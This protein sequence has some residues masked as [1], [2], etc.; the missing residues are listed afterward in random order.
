MAMSRPEL[1]Q[2]RVT[3]KE[4]SDRHRRSH[5]RENRDEPAEDEPTI[6]IDHLSFSCAD[7]Q[8]ACANVHIIFHHTHTRVGPILGQYADCAYFG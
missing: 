1:E 7:E 5:Y 4:H 3:F 2:T 6:T 8:R